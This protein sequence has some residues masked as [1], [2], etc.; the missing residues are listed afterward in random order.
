MRP[1][2]R[3]K[4][5]PWWPALPSRHLVR[6]HTISRQNE[7]TLVGAGLLWSHQGEPHT[8]EAEACLLDP[9]DATVRTCSS[10]R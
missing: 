10:P 1:C 4:R 9:S 6:T 7:A 5:L 3:P 8:W 2:P